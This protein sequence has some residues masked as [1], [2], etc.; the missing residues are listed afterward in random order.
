VDAIELDVAV[1]RDNVVVVS[2]D[3]VLEG[4]LCVGPASQ[5]ARAVIRES[6]F[7]QVRQWDCGSVRHPDFPRQATV[8]GARV[9]SLDEVL[10]LAGTFR[11]NIEVKSFPEQPELA[12]APADFARL[13]VALIRQHGVEARTIVQSFDFRVLH[14]V[15]E[16][17][18]ELA[19]AALF[20]DDPSFQTVFHGDFVAITRSAGAEIVAPLH[21]LATEE[22]VRRAH[23]AGIAVIPWTAN[24]EADWERLARAG[25]DGIIT[26]DP[27]ALIAYRGSA[28][29]LFG[30]I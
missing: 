10:R 22:R 18:P 25:V 1:T 6:T 23:A 24:S 14:A 26:D 4:P 7:D 16:L 3:P 12:P 21:T 8:P 19:L 27:A 11:F 28:P 13:V 20:E 9:P 5:G 17:A 29:S 30:G 2:H 15:K